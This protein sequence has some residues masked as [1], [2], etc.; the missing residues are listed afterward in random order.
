[1]SGKR[2]FE[3]SLKRLEEIVRTLEQDELGLEASLKA[4]EE[5]TKLADALAR[6]LEKAQARVAKL[7]RSKEGSPVLEEFDADTGNDDE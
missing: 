1:M 2:T 4:F 7:T 5:G 3:E 6:D